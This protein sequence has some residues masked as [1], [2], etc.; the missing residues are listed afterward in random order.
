M[1]IL[2]G[3][4]GEIMLAAPDIDLA[5]FEGQ[6]SRLG[7]AA[8]VSIF[9][10]ADD[11]ALSLSSALVGAR[12][13][14]GGLDLRKPEVQEEV[15]R[16]GVR[17]FDLTGK[18]DPDFFHHGAYANAPQVIAAIG[19]QLAEPRPQDKDATDVIGEPV[20]GAA[21]QGAPIAVTDLPPPV[22]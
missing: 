3:H 16:L 22:P 12:P 9:V 4:L 8:H 18:S 11:R 21:P 20:T 13:R 2:S 1:P 7:P 14:L 15:G 17:V 19:E 6:L 5:V 10:S